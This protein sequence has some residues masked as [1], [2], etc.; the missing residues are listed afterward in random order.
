MLSSIHAASSQDDSSVSSEDMNTAEPTWVAA[1]QPAVPESSPP[2]AERVSN[3]AAAI[4]EEDGESLR[5]HTA[6]CDFFPPL[7]ALFTSGRLQ[8][9]VIRETACLVL[10]GLIH[11]NPVL[12]GV[13][14][15][16]S[17]NPLGTPLPQSLEK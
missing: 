16:R 4:K 3:P 1:E 6:C 14:H 8:I 9:G 2:N 15:H 17:P 13:G 11:I 12:Q 10:S 7:L 5:R